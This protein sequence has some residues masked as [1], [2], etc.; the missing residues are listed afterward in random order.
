MSTGAGLSGGNSLWSSGFLPTTYSGVLLRNGRDPILNVATPENI[1]K[2]TQRDTFDLIQKLNQERLAAV[3]DPEIASRIAGVRD[4][5][6]TAILGTR[7][8]GPPQ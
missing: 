3:G 8:N 6:T 5:R 7:A 1:T 2:T 4:G